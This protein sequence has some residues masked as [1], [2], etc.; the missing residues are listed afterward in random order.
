MT[1]REAV[2]AP[3]GE[4]VAAIRAQAE[5]ARAL[6]PDAV[7]RQQ[8]L[9]KVNAFA[10]RFLADVETRPAFIETEHKGRAL[11][12]SPIGET[13]MDMDAVLKL[14]KDNVTDVG[15]SPVSPR[16]LAYIPP[17]SLY[18]GALGDFLAAVTNQFAGYFSSC[19]G[20]ARMEN[21]LLRW[22]AD[23]IGYPSTALGAMLSGGS[24]AILSSVVTARDA[25]GLK[26]RDYEKCVVYMTDLTH[27]AMDKA[28]R[29]AGMKEAVRRRVG[30]DDGCRMDPVRLDEAIRADHA[31]GLRPWLVAASAGTTD[32]GS[33]DPLDAL[34]DVAQRHRLWFHVDGAYGGLFIL[35]DLVRDRFAGIARADSVVLNAHKALF[36]PFGLAVVLVRE[37]ELLRRAHFHT[38]NY[39]QDTLLEEDEVSPADLGPELTRNFR[40]PRL[41]LPLKLLGVAPFRAA[42]TEK[43][44]LSRYAYEKL[45]GM[46]GFE[47]GPYPDLSVFAFRYVPKQGDP[48][49]FN[50]RLVEAIRRDGTILLSSTTLHGRY[51]IRFAV[52]SYRTHLDTIDLAI[53]VIQRHARQ[54][55]SD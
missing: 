46:P 29:I 8:M 32:L 3:A 30:M 51:M 39:L 21:Q 47:V 55:E 18:P 34:A 9:A 7:Q 45:K 28:L 33:V 42:L 1:A 54:L 11:Y 38:A 17:C 31:A 10:E 41:W 50:A 19:P 48:D 24:T 40:G 53:E 52:L 20:A 13:G 12:A 26:G 27:H 35:S 14:F 15:L 49:A 36:T 44:L 5:R 4:L 22:M 6:E 25:H 2:A 43:V 23:V 37:G 16:F